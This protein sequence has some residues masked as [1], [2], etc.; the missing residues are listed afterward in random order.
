MGS[1]NEFTLVK[2]TILG[3]IRSEKKQAAKSTAIPFGMERL[4]KPENVG[5]RFEQMSKQEKTEHIRRVGVETV[6]KQLRAARG[7]TNGSPR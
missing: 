7:G 1:L 5:K 4:S 6:M 3:E 2:N